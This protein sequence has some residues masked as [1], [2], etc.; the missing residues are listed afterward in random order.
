MSMN[1]N[2][3]Y[4]RPSEVDTRRGLSLPPFTTRHA[5]P[6][7]ESARRRCLHHS[8]HG[9]CCHTKMKKAILLTTSVRLMFSTAR[10][11]TKGV[12]TSRMSPRRAL[13]RAVQQ[14]HASY[15]ENKRQ[16]HAARCCR[17]KQYVRSGARTRGSNVVTVGARRVSVRYMRQRA[18][19]QA[20]RAVMRGM[21]RA[22][23][24]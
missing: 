14:R 23:M 12:V 3:R 1:A 16:R 17:A 18:M 7:R 6:N 15:A 8:I 19:S 2:H 24:E 20:R 13:K 11:V 9:E 22:Y 5:E 4:Q 10:S 21:M